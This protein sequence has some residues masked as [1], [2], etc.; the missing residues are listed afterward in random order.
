MYT[1]KAK[2][3]KAAIRAEMGPQD[4]PPHPRSWGGSANVRHWVA[5]KERG[6][7]WRIA[8][9][10]TQRLQGGTVKMW[11]WVPGTFTEK[12][13]YSLAERWNDK[14]NLPA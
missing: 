7:P 10:M 14:L 6:Q 4:Q 8:V 9:W 5:V 2:L 11:W 1:P 13:A 3:R 12:K